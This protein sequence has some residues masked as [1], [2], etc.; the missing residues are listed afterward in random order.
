MPEEKE[1]KST[2]TEDKEGRTLSRRDFAIGSIAFISGLSSEAR[3][4]AAA[5]QLKLEKS[6]SIRDL[7]EDRHILDEDLI[8]VIQHAEKT[9]EK[10]YQ[11]DT[12]RF[13]A[14]LRIKNVYFYVE[15][16]IIEGGYR[17]HTAYSHRFSLD[18][19]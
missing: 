6:D 7:L 10:L 4:G 19:G 13:L 2:T 5:D 3:T 11:T 18:E 1:N 12:D 8:P 17:I 9:G 15:Y 16:S 14:K